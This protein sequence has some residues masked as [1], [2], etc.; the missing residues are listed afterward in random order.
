MKK[1]PILIPLLA[2]VAVLFLGILIF[3]YVQAKK[4]NPQ[5]IQSAGELRSPGQAW[6]PTLQNT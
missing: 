2:V 4:A 3:V 6:R 5:M 1:I